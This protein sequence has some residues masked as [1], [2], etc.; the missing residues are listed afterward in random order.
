MKR[1]G[2]IFDHQFFRIVFRAFC[3]L[4]LLSGFTERLFAQTAAEIA[5]K[6]ID[7]SLDS[8]SLKLPARLFIPENYNAQ[9]SYPV[10]LTL[11]GIGERGTD[12]NLH[13]VRNNL[14]TTWGKD[15]FQ[16]DNP[17]F[18]FSPQC[19]STADSSW[20]DRDVYLSVNLLLDSIINNYSIDTNRI[21]ITGLSMGGYGTWIYMDEDPYKFAA[22]M[23]L[24]GGLWGVDDKDS[25]IVRRFK[26]IPVWNF[27]GAK[28]VTVNTNLSRSIMRQ[29]PKFGL[30]PLYTHNYYR[31]EFSLEDSIIEHFIDCHADIIYSELPN[32]GHSIWYEVYGMPLA[33]KWLFRQRKHSRDNIIVNRQEL[34][35]NISGTHEFFF[36]VSDQTDSVS[37]WIGHVNSAKWD[38]ING[39]DPSSGKYIFDPQTVSDHPYGL[40]KFIAHDS[41]GYAIGKDFTDTL[42]INNEGNGPPYIELIDDYFLNHT[43]INEDKYTMSVLLADPESDPLHVS[44]SISYDKG[45]NFEAYW[46]SDA[47]EG[48]YEQII[49]LDRLDYSVGTVI[50]AEV[51]DGV[52]TETVQTLYFTNR[53]GHVV[54]SESYSAN[55]FELFPNP[56]SDLL[57][58]KTRYSAYQTIEITSLNGQ[59]I[60]IE[61][62]KG[63]SHQL[64][65]S[66]FRKGVYFITIRSE[67]FATTRKIIKL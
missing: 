6:F 27:H 23:P 13:I 17:C 1:I 67:D 21:Y 39:I 52:N 66:S 49:E 65:L 31:Y 63:T 51:S 47:D 10:V 61:E 8:G 19:P 64:D 40:L 5:A 24:C 36:S 45:E 33:K 29:Y 41:A 38:Y 3:C 46:D 11:H 60:L 37:I 28:D 15:D 14:A 7:F 22:A 59:Q 4:I 56:V 2:L 57:T 53:K 42:C 35:L 43:S 55:N 26:H 48:I 32:D 62:M 44:F 54:S 12:N 58:I 50:M 18:I 20:I 30:E 34:K 9:E 25:A 16:A